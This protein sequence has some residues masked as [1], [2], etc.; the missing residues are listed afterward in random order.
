M[1]DIS[2]IINH[3]GEERDKYFNTISPPLFQT[4]NFAFRDVEALRKAIADDKNNN[5]YSSPLTQSPATLGVDIV[6]F[7]K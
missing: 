6:L 7:C 5:S 3:L 2:Y 1:K 4:S